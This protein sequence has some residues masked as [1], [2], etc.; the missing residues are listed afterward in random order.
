MA[1]LIESLG[2]SLGKVHI[3]LLAYMCAQYR[4]GATGPLTSFLQSLGVPVPHDPVP[5]REWKAA[6][7]VRLDLAIFDGD[8]K[9]PCIIVEMKVD[10]HE[11][12]SNDIGKTTAYA[13]A[14]PHVPHRLFVTLGHGEYYH[15]PYDD[16]FK[17]IKLPAFAQAVQAASTAHPTMGPIHDWALALQHELDRRHAVTN[18]DRRQLQTYRPG[19]WNINFLGQL[20]EALS[21]ALDVASIERNST[22]YTHGTRPDTIL[23]FGWTKYP[24]YAE[25]NNNGRLNCKVTFEE[26]TTADERRTLYLDTV[27]IL[28]ETMV[29]HAL[30]I[31]PLNPSA[32]T[33]TIA[34]L[35]IGLSTPDGALQYNGNAQETL[36]RLAQFLCAFYGNPI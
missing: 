18:N 36:T 6:P 9:I 19:S 16:Q 30:G 1:N 27:H 25:I 4:E 17:W 10:D 7:G 33:M 3:G 13:N 34:S 2:Y 32:N 23:N 12:T 20:K 11:S 21:L 31:Q 15:P 14:T 26:C 28:Q 24:R 35:D 22:C 8:A 5:H 29:G